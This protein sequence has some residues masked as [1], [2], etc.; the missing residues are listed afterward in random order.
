MKLQIKSKTRGH[1][2]V[3]VNVDAKDKYLYSQCI[4]A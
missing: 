4:D 1:K 2:E 3:V